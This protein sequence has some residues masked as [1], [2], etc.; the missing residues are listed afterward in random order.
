MT[1]EGDSD[2]GI[3]KKNNPYNVQV[4]QLWSDND[5]RVNRTLYLA[6][7]DQGKKF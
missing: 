2:M 3:N 6:K 4:G 7:Y 1:S 5:R